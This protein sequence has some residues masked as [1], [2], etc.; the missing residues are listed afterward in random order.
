MSAILPPGD[1]HSP[2]PIMG[3]DHAAAILRQ[4]GGR[5]DA[6]LRRELDRFLASRP[7]LSHA[8]RTAIVRAMSRFRNQLLHRPRYTLRA[9]AAGEVSAAPLLIEAV[10]RLFG[11]AEPSS[12]D[13]S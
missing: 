13:A 11:L 5:T 4:I 10:R 8:D 7:G 3:R 6:A 12:S 2:L 9:A 1:L